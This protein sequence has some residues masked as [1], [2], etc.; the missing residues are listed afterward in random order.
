M[1][2]RRTA[3]TLTG[4]RPREI[5]R[6]GARVVLE[7]EIAPIDDIRSSAWYRRRVAGNLLE[8]FLDRCLEGSPAPR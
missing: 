4:Q 8:E 5:D 3:A 1:S 6:A 7:P 2:A